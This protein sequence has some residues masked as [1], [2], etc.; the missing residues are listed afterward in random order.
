VGVGQR[1]TTIL[2]GQADDVWGV[3]FLVLAGL[4]ALGIYG[5]LTGPA[6]RALKAGAGDL[7]GWGRV[8]VPVALALLGWVL[9]RGRPRTV[10]HAGSPSRTALGCVAALVAVSGLLQL[11]E[12]PAHWHGAVRPLRDAG[13]L[14]GAAV[15]I[16]LRDGVAVWGAAFVLLTLLGLSVLVLTATPV[17][18]A[19]DRVA[20]AG[21]ATA[22]ALSAAGRWVVDIGQ[23]HERRAA[24]GRHP[25]AVDPPSPPRRPRRVPTPTTTGR[26]QGRC[27]TGRAT[28][29][30]TQEATC[31]PPLR[32]ARHRERC[33]RSPRCA[34]RCPTRPPIPISCRSRWDG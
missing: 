22:T 9:V 26:P 11:F 27:P 5:N 32:A 30:A 15:G 2:G 1:L 12:G 29:P 33:A 25:T 31:P 23:R 8:L 13:G 18:A 6:G 19:S 3:A 20:R 21:R 4:A 24:A 17:R 34:C 28:T 16:P 7:V 10:E 14:L